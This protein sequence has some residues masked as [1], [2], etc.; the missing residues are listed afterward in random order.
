MHFQVK[1]LENC[2]KKL[3]CE[4]SANNVFRSKEPTKKVPRNIFRSFAKR[5]K[6]PLM[7]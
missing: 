3:D 7:F 6:V 1:I 5:K 4:K 2:T